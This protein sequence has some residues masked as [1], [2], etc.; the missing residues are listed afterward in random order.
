M[1]ECKPARTSA[2]AKMK[3]KTL[4]PLNPACSL[5]GKRQLTLL[6]N[7]NEKFMDLNTAFQKFPR[8]QLTIKNNIEHIIATRT[9]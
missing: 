9:T 5:S 3:K 1:V 7:R 6:I 4:L 2:K 8:L